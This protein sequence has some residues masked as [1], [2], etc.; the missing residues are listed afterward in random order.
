MLASPS[1]Q[2]NIRCGQWDRKRSVAAEFTE[3]SRPFTGA[4]GRIRRTTRIAV[5]IRLFNALSCKVGS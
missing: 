5:E 2:L 4:N 3:D 1:V